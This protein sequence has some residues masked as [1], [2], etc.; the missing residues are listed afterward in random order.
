MVSLMAAR[1]SSSAVVCPI[2]ALPPHGAR[3]SVMIRISSNEWEMKQIRNF[4]RFAGIFEK[5]D[6]LELEAVVQGGQ[7]LVEEQQARAAKHRPAEGHPLFLPAR[8]VPHAP[9]EKARDL[10]DL[11]NV[12]EGDFPRA[13]AGTVL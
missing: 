13:P 7:G 6:Y 12:I 3:A 4:K 1:A 10:Q 2:R 8:Q 5:R 9:V 11:N